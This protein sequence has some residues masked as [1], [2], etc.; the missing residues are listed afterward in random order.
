MGRSAPRV[1]NAGWIIRSESHLLLIINVTAVLF[2]F[3]HFSFLLILINVMMLFVWMIHSLLYLKRAR[4]MISKVFLLDSDQLWFQYWWQIKCRHHRLW[5]NENNTNK[6]TCITKRSGMRSYMALLALNQV[7]SS[8][9]A[10]T[11]SPCRTLC[12]QHTWW[13]STGFLSLI[14]NMASCMLIRNDDYSIWN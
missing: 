8:A 13:I 6:T 14:S 11:H 5:L 2:C 1:S 7:H 3:N 10:E 4:K 12:T 9:S